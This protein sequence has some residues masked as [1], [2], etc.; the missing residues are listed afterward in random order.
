MVME[1]L[2]TGGDA[3][4][5]SNKLARFD[6]RPVQWIISADPV[7]YPVALEAMRSRAAAIAAGAA[8]EA[9]WLLEHPPLYTAGT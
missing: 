4:E 7:P 6:A 3:C 1:A 9:I 5:T 8:E 2:T